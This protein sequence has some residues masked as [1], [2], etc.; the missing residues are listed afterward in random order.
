MIFFARETVQPTPRQ[1]WRA[2]A[3]DR[4]ARPPAAKGRGDSMLGRT[5]FACPE[6]RK[7]KARDARRGLAAG[8]KISPS[9]K[10]MNKRGT[11]RKSVTTSG[12]FLQRI[13]RG[14]SGTVFSGSVFLAERQTCSPC[15]PRSSLNIGRGQCSSSR[16]PRSPSGVSCWRARRLWTPGRGR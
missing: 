15:R 4:A 12:R 13:R 11:A 3:K 1:V 8:Q 10:R 16:R 2:T 5:R 6:G 14:A 7:E 9:R